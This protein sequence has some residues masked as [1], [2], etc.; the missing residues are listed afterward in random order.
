MPTPTAP[1]GP[2][3]NVDLSVG[4]TAT[5]LGGDAMVGLSSVYPSS[6]V[7]LTFT[8][9]SQSCTMSP[10]PA[11]TYVAHGVTRGDVESYFSVTLVGIAKGSAKLEVR[12]IPESEYRQG[13]L[14]FY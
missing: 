4:Q 2:P 8:S 3:E 1:T 12:K 6:F 11:Q 10:S 7:S 5:V 9:G 14:C 13:N